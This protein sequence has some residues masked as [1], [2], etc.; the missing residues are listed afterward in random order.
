MSSPRK[1]A[2][3][4][5]Y[6]TAPRSVEVLPI[7][8]H[9]GEDE[10]EVTS[11]LMGISAGSE[12]LAYN[13]ALPQGNHGETLSSLQDASAYPVKYGYVNVG[14]TAD[15]S[16]LFAFYPHQDFFSIPPEECVFLP[17]DVSN[18]DA[19]FLANMETALGI[20]HDAR[21]LVGDVLFVAGQGVVGL[22][23]AE[24]L[25]RSGHSRVFTA[26]LSSMRREWSEKLG[27][28][29]LDPETV[30]V[31]DYLKHNTGGRG[32]DIAINVS[33]SETGLQLC[34][35]ATAFEG[36]VIEAS[37]YGSKDTTVSLG[38]AFHRRRLTIKSSQVSHIA[39][40]LSPRWTKERRMAFTIDLLREIK[41]GKYI[42][43]RVPLDRGADA[44]RL[45]QEKRN[46]VLQIALEP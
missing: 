13:G 23:V 27:C 9:C 1:A 24:L 10:I 42:T 35:D 11:T 15:G 5:L 33:A 37:W 44:F 29:A 16:R 41:P 31:A 26:D 30:D 12:M 20:V 17:D 32:V 7:T 28:T 46:E 2:A 34:V 25:Q 22:L 19:I 4:A 14:K 6:I 45:L 18:E 21:P 3:R 8:V 40:A 39:A 36:T 38:R 43:H